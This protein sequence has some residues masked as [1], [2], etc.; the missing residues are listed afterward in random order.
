MWNLWWCLLIML[1]KCP[2]K[3]MQSMR[4]WLKN[5]VDLEEHWRQFRSENARQAAPGVRPHAIDLLAHSIKWPDRTL[6]AMLAAGATPIGRQETTG[7]FRSK[8]TEA[9]MRSE[10][11]VQEGGDFMQTLMAQKPPSDEQKTVVCHRKSRS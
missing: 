7:I 11:F 5:A 6:P 8:F 10:D 9:E 2:N 3:K 1:A 4:A